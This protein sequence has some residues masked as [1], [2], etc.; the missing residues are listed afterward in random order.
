[1]KYQIGNYNDVPDFIYGITREI[2]E[3][4]GIGGKIK[5]YYADDCLVR[6][7]TGI[8]TDNLGVTAQTLQ[9]LHQFPDR[10]LVGEDVIWSG[11][12][13]GS[14]LSSHRLISVMRHT[15]DGIYGKATGRVVRSRIIADCYCVD[16]Q[17]KEEWLARDQAAFAR[18]MGIDHEPARAGYRPPRTRRDRRSRVLQARARHPR[19]LP[20]RAPEGRR[21]HRLLRRL[22]IDLGHEGNVRNQGSVFPRRDWWPRRAATCF[23]DTAISTASL[24]PISRHFRMLNSPSRA[25]S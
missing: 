20:A 15:G 7:A 23:Q 14:F 1:M 22:A 25:Q 16:T 5:S 21:C 6:A 18:C 19:P 24:F 12:D 4:R 13:D 17:V 8:A 9:T 3:D 2:W 11:Y 10:Q